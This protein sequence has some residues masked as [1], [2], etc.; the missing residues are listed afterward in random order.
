M[1]V[2]RIKEKHLIPYSRLSKNFVFLFMLSLTLQVDYGLH[3][4]NPTMV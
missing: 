1:R 2:Q 4:L 3:V